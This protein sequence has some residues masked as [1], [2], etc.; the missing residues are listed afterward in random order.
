MGYSRKVTMSH[1]DL[2]ERQ[3]RL[4][5]RSELLRGSL[6]TQSRV[7]Q[8][9]LALADRVAD[10]LQ[11]LYRNPYFPAAAVAVLVVLKPGRVL[12][13]GGRMWWVWTS[14]EKAQKLLN[15]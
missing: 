11:W 7:I 10:G 3:L 6:A 9:P 15:R 14:L 8:R 1:D 4:I 5:A 13:W 2:I 12:T